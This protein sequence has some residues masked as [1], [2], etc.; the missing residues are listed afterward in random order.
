MP[1]YNLTDNAS[2][3]KET[4]S[5]IS[6]NHYNGD[7]ILLSQIKKS[8]DLQGLKDHVSIP[9]G[10]AR[11]V[12]GGV[13]GYLPEG[14]SESGSQIE[15]TAKDVYGRAVVSRKSMKAAMTDRGAFVRFTKR[16][17]EQCVLSYD[18]FCNMILHGEGYGRIG[19]TYTTGYVSGGATAPILQ[20]LRTTSESTN[21]WFPRRLEENELINIGDSGDTGTEDGLFKITAVD[22]TNY[23]ITLSRVSGSYDLSSGTNA[24]SRFLYVQRTWHAMPQ[25]L[26]SIVMATSGTLYGVAYSRRWSSLLQDCS[27]APISI[28]LINDLV[29]RQITRVG[30][31]FGPNLILTSPEIW[32]QLADQHENQ[33]RYTL[34]PRDKGL[35]GN[36]NFSFQGIEYVT[37]DGQ[38]IG[39]MS[40]RH[41]ISTRLYALNTDFIE[42]HH[43][44]DQGWFD[45]D[46]RVF[47]RVAN[48]DEYEARYG[49]YW[50]CVIHPTYQCALYNLGV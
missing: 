46:G 5:E 25:G 12:G 23:R 16:P 15:I 36:A 35:R 26:E 6:R 31:G 24:D 40:D 44:P 19:K 11:G 39:I 37:P 9:L 10:M 7:T 47:Q 21:Q 14:G 42:M 41:C 30:K 13:G 29:N 50:E 27:G 1:T 34:Q 2:L 18:N 43:M 45:E 3:F 32:A 28:P 4:Y 20:M 33:K 22:E 49:G 48:K 38:V 17:V 8:Y